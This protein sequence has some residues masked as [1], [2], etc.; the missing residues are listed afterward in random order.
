MKIDLSTRLYSPQFQRRPNA[1]EMKRY[2]SSV[3]EGLKVLD[4]KFG[5]II[6]NSSVPSRPK[7]NIGIGSLLSKNAE[8]IFLPFLAA[9]AVTTVQ[10]E[11]DNI[12]GSYDPSPY[13]PQSITKNIYMIPIERLASKEYGHLLNVDDIRQVISA[14]QARKNPNTVDYK[15]VE[16]NY[17]KIL[18]NAY[19]LLTE[20]IDE[21]MLQGLSPENRLIHIAL[22]N[23]FED[24]KKE[25]YKEIEPSAIYEIIAKKNNNENWRTWNEKERN[26]YM[27]S[28]KKEVKKMARENFSAIDFYAFKQWL[29]DREVK[30]SIARNTEL[31]IKVIGD[32][33]IAF[34]PVEIW[35]NQDLFMENLSLGCRPDDFAPNGQRW[36]FAILKPES[37]FNPDGT[38][39][40]GGELIKKRYEKAFESSPGG[41]R[42]DHVI[43]LIDP[44]VYSTNEPKMTNEN[45]GRLY[46]SPEH[47]LFSKYAR[48]N[49]KDFSAILEKIVFPAA[50]KYGLTKDDIICEDLGEITP[51]VQKV[52]KELNLSGIAVTEFD[53]RGKETPENKVIMLGSHDNTSFVEY[54]NRMFTQKENDHRKEKA[55]KL[56]EDTAVPGENIEEY[57]SKIMN[58]KT[59]FMAANFAELFTSSAKRIQIFFTDFFGIGKTYN[60]PGTTENCWVLRTPENHEKTY[61]ANLKKG[62]ALNLPEAIARAIR[63]KGVEFSDKHQDLLS[64]LDEFTKILK[65]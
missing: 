13:S 54:T 22:K 9:N 40:R 29:V 8:K 44:Y 12:R 58:E 28:D 30:K 38:L 49:D 25:N 51:P 42:I 37:I 27:T 65:S 10:Q 5:L 33:P 4:K 23:E 62:T 43:G 1:A 61:Y 24:Y 11:P 47:P 50:E 56:A 18:H 19:M 45:A 15:F 20:E 14:N 35:M 2:S 7:F 48:T 36:D 63:Q 60:T 59:S 34:T 17:N 53:Y 3:A 32:S 57:K 55:E 6:H 31:G 16:E 41:V 64:R 21:Q 39:G 52:M 26:L 46:S